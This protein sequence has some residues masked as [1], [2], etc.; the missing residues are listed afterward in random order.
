MSRKLDAAIAELLGYKVSY[1][2]WVREE[3]SPEP[4]ED[5]DAFAAC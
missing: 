5:Y 4:W 1:V 2:K 3:D